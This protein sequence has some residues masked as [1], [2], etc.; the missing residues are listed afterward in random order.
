M[1]LVL[2]IACMRPGAPTGMA[3]ENSA[4]NEDGK[5]VELDLSRK[6][7]EENPQPRHNTMNG[8]GTALVALF[9]SGNAHWKNASNSFQDTVTSPRQRR[10]QE[11]CINHEWLHDLFD[12]L[13]NNGDDNL[14]LSEWAAG[15]DNPWKDPMWAKL[16]E[17]SMNP[18]YAQNSEQDYL[19]DS[20]VDKSEFIGRWMDAVRA[21]QASMQQAGKN[22]GTW[23]ERP[24]E[25]EYGQAF[26]TT[27]GD[28]DI[29]KFESWL[30]TTMLF[31]SME[32]GAADGCIVW[33]EFKQDKVNI[34]FK[35]ADKPEMEKRFAQF[36]EG[37]PEGMALKVLHNYLVE[38]MVFNGQGQ[39]NIKQVPLET[40]VKDFH[41]YKYGFG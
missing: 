19:T 32:L 8:G 9:A 34:M 21:A 26:L 31:R 37:C 3:L 17:H 24:Y 6:A 39:S 20:T 11:H 16:N 18:R 12:V 30:Y 23:P 25:K 22:I 10:R 27:H 38:S 15:V 13:D 33:E 4:V 2:V 1:S 40:A 7:V 29:S 14:T 41:E 28:L 35:L 5:R 36:K